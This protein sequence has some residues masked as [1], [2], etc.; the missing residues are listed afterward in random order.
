MSAI[1]V[2]LMIVGGSMMAISQ[3]Q[4]S[5]A[6]AQASEYN[7]R[8]AEAQA[9][10]IKT[11]G[12][13][14]QKT[15]EQQSAFERSKIVREKAKTTSAQRAKYAASGVRVD[16]GSPL[17]VMAQSAAEY[18][19]DIAANRYNLEVDKERIGY[20]TRVGV[21][22]SRSEAAYSRLLGKQYKR[23][24]YRQAGSTLLTTAG[25]VGMM[26]GWGAGTASSSVGP[27]GKGNIIR[28]RGI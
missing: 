9:K 2:P 21:A 12:E 18:E 3:V 4:G 10:A 26:S 15:L 25:T 7:A 20:E 11:S 17:E 5:R 6:M 8:V 22:Q 16:V 1:A 28:F 19:L 23:A 14:E 13:F 24:G 27:M